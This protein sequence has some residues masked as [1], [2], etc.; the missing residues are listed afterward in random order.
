MDDGKRIVCGNWLADLQY[1]CQANGM[2]DGICSLSASRAKDKA[3][4]AHAFGIG[5]GHDPTAWRL[6]RS[7]DVSRR[8]AAG[9]IDDPGIAAMCGYHL[10]KGLKRGTGGN[11]LAECSFS[12]LDIPCHPAQK[13]HVR[14]ESKGKRFEVGRS[15]SA[16][17]IDGLTDLDGIASRSA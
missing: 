4:A 2:V 17:A 16:K 3:G 15:V 9:V 8:Q 14:S 10:G 13:Q 12:A 11:L 5:P 6:D 1:T 7:L